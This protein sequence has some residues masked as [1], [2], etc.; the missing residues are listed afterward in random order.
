MAFYPNSA[1][2]N[3]RT[4]LLGVYMGNFSAASWTNK[5]NEMLA[6]TRTYAIKLTNIYDSV[7]ETEILI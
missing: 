3:P 5:L 2:V 1:I 4:F 6:D 7:S